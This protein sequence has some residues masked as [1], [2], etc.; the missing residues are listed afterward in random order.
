MGGKQSKAPD[1][2]STVTSNLQQQGKGADDVEIGKEG[3]LVGSSSLSL[4]TKSAN[5][6]GEQP[7][8][9]L[10]GSGTTIENQDVPQMKE[11]VVAKAGK[12]DGELRQPELPKNATKLPSH[13][14]SG[15]DN[16]TRLGV[17][18]TNQHLQLKSAQL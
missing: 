3:V 8:I 2:S 6:Q 10:P 14:F 16:T 9:N 17:V 4:N 5:L 12:G 11:I 18:D 15:H 13:N 1:A 7:T